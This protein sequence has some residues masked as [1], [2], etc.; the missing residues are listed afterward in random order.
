MLACSRQVGVRPSG[1]AARASRAIRERHR[2][3]RALANRLRT[4]RDLEERDLLLDVGG[5]EE[6]IHDLRDARA[7]ESE[8]ARHVGVVGELAGVNTAPERVCEL[9]RC[10]WGTGAGATRIS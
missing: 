10:A 2:G 6:Q 9:A 7:G 5:E 1:A 4:G 8:G 3:E